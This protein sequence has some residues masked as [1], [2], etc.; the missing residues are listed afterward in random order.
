[1][2]KL[3]INKENEQNKKAENESSEKKA[4]ANLKDIK[5]KYSP[6]KHPLVF[7][8][9]NK[10]GLHSGYKKQEMKVKYGMTVHKKNS[11]FN[12]N[13]N[14]FL[15]NSA[16]AG[17]QDDIK[18][19]S[20]SNSPQKQNENNDRSGKK[21]KLPKVKGKLQTVC[22]DDPELIKTIK[23][24]KHINNLC[25]EEYQLKLIEVAKKILDNEN[26]KNLVNKFKDISEI[27]QKKDK[28]KYNKSNNRWEIMVKVISR[29]I[30]QFLV[31]KLK[32]QK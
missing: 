1:M 26:L 17:S 5:A 32:S 3:Q 19:N 6:L 13:R 29:Y 15:N 23:S 25:L 21:E 22:K 18:I 16:V 24:L 11:G 4:K 28:V 14:S 9:L 7:P 10:Y 8:E 2:K 27:S 30:P 31:E 20:A 12:K